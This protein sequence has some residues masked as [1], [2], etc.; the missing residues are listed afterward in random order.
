MDILQRLPTLYDF[1]ISAKPGDFLDRVAG[2]VTLV[3]SDLVAIQRDIATIR[4]LQ[5]HGFFELA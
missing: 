2:R 1:S 3:H 4:Q 5:S